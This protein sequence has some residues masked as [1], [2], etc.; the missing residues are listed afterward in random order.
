MTVKNTA[1]GPAPAPEGDPVDLGAAARAV[2][3]VLREAGGSLRVS[4]V[5]ERMGTHDNTV[6]THLAQL[7]ERRLATATTAPAQGRGRPATLYEAGP[8][9]GART[10]EYRALTSAF[11]ADLIAHG[12]GPEVRTRARSIGRAWGEQMRTAD[13][14]A[15]ARLD[16][17]LAD[18]GFGP[19]REG[20]VVR[21]TTCPLLEAALE[22][23]EVICQVHLGLVAGTLGRREEDP[24]IELTPFAEPG[25]CLLRVPAER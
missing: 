10:A 7:V 2:L 15:S 9:P 11:A 16:A 4:D 23:P 25:A 13:G 20:E 1:A 17:T 3:D 6:R 12:D 22:H 5:A 14:D 18:L 19:V 24:P 21:L 8:R